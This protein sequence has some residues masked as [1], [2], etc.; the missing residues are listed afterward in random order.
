MSDDD[1]GLTNQVTGSTSQVTGSVTTG[2][3]MVG[4]RGNEVVAEND[5]SAGDSPQFNVFV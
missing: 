2:N 4:T 3:E 5:K 1:V